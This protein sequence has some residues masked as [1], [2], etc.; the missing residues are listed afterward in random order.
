[1][2]RTTASNIT[3]AQLDD[4]YERLALAAELADTGY[5]DHIERRAIIR[6]LCAGEISPQQA[7]DEDRDE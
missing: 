2:K 4:L 6:R 3:D 5:S 7:R 1:M